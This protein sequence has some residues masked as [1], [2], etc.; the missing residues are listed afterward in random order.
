VDDSIGVRSMKV[1]YQVILYKSRNFVV[2]VI[3]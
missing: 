3:L 2:A 1:R